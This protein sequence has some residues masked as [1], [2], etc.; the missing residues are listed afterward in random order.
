MEEKKYLF[1]VTDDHV[2]FRDGLQ[3]MLEKHFTGCTVHH[4]CNGQQMLDTAA[5]ADYDIIFCDIRMPVLNGMEATRRLMAENPAANIIAI[6]MYNDEI[7]MV[8]MLHAGARGFVCKESG[9]EEIIKAMKAVMENQYFVAGALDS[10]SFKRFIEQHKN[11]LAQNITKREKEILMLLANGDNTKMIA[12][13]LGLSCRTIDNHRSHLLQKT[14]A[15]NI[16]G[17]IVYAKE[18]EWI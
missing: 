5:K 6:T 7:N 17:L 13:A 18:R 12:D 9:R 4:A 16:A 14:G 1:L 2:L 8:E 3:L 11:V 10:D 15:H